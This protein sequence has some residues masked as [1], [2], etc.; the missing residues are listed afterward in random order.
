MGRHQAQPW[1]LAASSRTSSSCAAWTLSSN[2]IRRWAPTIL[3]GN[4]P[5]T[6]SLPTCERETLRSSVA[7]WV[8]SSA[9]NRQDGDRVIVRYLTENPEE[10]HESLARDG[11][12]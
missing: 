7:R 10:E 1:A 9:C 3:N 12:A 8:V 6:S 11:D 4:F 5:C 2:R